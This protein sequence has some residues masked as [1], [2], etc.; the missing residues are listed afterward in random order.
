MYPPPISV[1]VLC[2]LNCQVHQTLDSM[3]RKHQQLPGNI[4]RGLMERFYSSSSQRWGTEFFLAATIAASSQFTSKRKKH[5]SEVDAVGGCSSLAAG[6]SRYQHQVICSGFFMYAER[7]N[8][9]RTL[10]RG[11]VQRKTFMTFVVRVCVCCIAMFHRYEK[12]EQLSDLWRASRRSTIGLFRHWF[13][14]IFI[15]NIDQRCYF[16]HSVVIVSVQLD[17]LSVYLR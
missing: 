15:A 5:Y 1:C 7:M 6:H 11:W 4:L 2:F 13:P 9:D 12:G 10:W 16:D 17:C 14:S 3:I 8:T